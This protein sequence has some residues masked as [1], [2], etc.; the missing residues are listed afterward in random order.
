[1]DT[2]HIDLAFICCSGVD[3]GLQNG[4]VCILKLNIFAYKGNVHGLLRICQFIEKL[5]PTS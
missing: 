5:I 4:F 1:M 2:M 3:E